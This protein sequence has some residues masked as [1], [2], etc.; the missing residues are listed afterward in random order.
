MIPI[1]AAILLSGQA[2]ETAPADCSKAMT[3][4]EI[5]ACAGLDLERETARMERYLAA[6]RTR[7]RELDAV[8]DVRDRSHQQ[9]YLQNA[10]KAWEAYAAIVCDGV[11]DEWKGGT[12]RN[13][14]YIGCQVEMTRE[15]TRVIW[16][17]YLTYADST[18]PILPE[19]VDPATDAP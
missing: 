9:V 10:Q 13:A 19:P 12:I 15:R 18:P 1:L 4:P 8:D 5:N 14:M 16:R 6:A 7:A 17:D 11:Y 3:T 2:I